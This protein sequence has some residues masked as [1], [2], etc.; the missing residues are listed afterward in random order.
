MSE[1]R[2]AAQPLWSG[3][4][5]SE[6]NQVF[7]LYSV[8][9]RPAGTEAIDDVVGAINEL[10]E[11]IEAEKDL[12]TVRGIY[13]ANNLR[14]DADVIVFAH[15][16]KLG[17]LQTFMRRLRATRIFRDLEAVWQV[18][19]VYNDVEAERIHKPAFTVGEPA[20]NWVVIYPFVR[21][22]EW[23]LMEPRE[24]GRIMREHGQV[25]NLY[26]GVVTQTMHAFGMSDYEWI[27]A[28]ESDDSTELV[29]LL[30]AMR[31]TEARLHVRHETPFFY[32]RRL[33]DL[34]EL[35]MVLGYAPDAR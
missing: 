15:G 4:P 11:T 32:G 25:G 33:Q 9:R 24:H 6:R 13:D 28:F 14:A 30:R 1:V 16:R 23:Y 12:A 5:E 2:T 29:D 10:K 22:Y 27:L 35:P 7:A 19:G 17:D 3:T 18:P 31:Y 34:A 8:F 26:A 20:R 21:T